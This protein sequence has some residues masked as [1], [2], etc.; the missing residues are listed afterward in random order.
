MDR[1]MPRL[2]RGGREAHA[3]QVN[4]RQQDGRWVPERGIEGHGQI[5]LKLGAKDSPAQGTFGTNERASNGLTDRSHRR[6][7]H[8]AIAAP[9]A[10]HIRIRRTPP[11]PCRVWSSSITGGGG[12]RRD[13]PEEVSLCVVMMVSLSPPVPLDT[14]C[15]AEST[16]SPPVFFRLSRTSLYCARTSGGI[17]STLSYSAPLNTIFRLT[18]SR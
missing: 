10:I 14:R 1:G 17:A 13:A 11:P 16:S 8:Q 7:S 5:T 18:G 4:G 6:S 3:H 12:G 9:S 15:N 2:R